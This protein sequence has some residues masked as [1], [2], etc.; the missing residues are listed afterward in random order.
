MLTMSFV[1][2]AVLAIW[3][4]KTKRVRSGSLIG[5]VLLGLILMG[6]PAGPP[7]A[8]AVQSAADEIGRGAVSAFH[9]VM[10]R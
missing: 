9:A 1:V 4:I 8:A 5:G 3:G 10:G 7:L 2:G 6:T